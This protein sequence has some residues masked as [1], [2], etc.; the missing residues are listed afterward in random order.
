MAAIPVR[1]AIQKLF[2]R[3]LFLTNITISGTLFGLGDTIQQNIEIHVK[4]EKNAFDWAR[5]A[6]MAATGMFVLGPL[7]HHWFRMLD[8]R[9]PQRD[10]MTIIKKVATDQLVSGPPF[11]FA[12][13]W[14]MGTLEGD[15]F[16]DI[17]HE[18]RSKFLHVFL[19]DCAIWVPMQCLNFYF[20][21]PQHRIVFVSCIF[22]VWNT[23][24]SYFK[25]KEFPARPMLEMA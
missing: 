4:R 16:K 1:K 8:R 14:S 10:G 7:S 6:R 11:Q 22:V 18:Y 20:I 19:A 13:F 3:H 5:T 24:L 15:K 23:I 2:E 9:W 12:F 17:C 25:H 21:R